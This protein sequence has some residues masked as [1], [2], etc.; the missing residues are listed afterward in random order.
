MNYSWAVNSQGKDDIRPNATGTRLFGKVIRVIYG[1]H[2]RGIHAAAKVGLGIA[3]I[4]LLHLVA[5]VLGG[6]SCRVAC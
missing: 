3:P 4:A 1:I 2:T 5:Q 6:P